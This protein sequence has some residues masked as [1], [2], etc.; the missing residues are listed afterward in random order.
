M[1]SAVGLVT[2]ARHTLLQLSTDH[3]LPKTGSILSSLF[4]YSVVWALG[5][6]NW[7]R[8]PLKFYGSVPPCNTGWHSLRPSLIP[9]FVTICQPV[10]S[11]HVAV[12]DN[13]YITASFHDNLDQHAPE[14]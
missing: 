3:H 4:R 12:M 10:W 14:K 1:G 7:T 9:G 13:T 11:N 8:S 2:Q 6:K 5:A